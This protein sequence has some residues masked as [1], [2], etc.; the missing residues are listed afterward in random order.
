MLLDEGCDIEAREDSGKTTLMFEAL[1]GEFDC[2][3][4][5]IQAD[6]DIHA[7]DNHNQTAL[8]ARTHSNRANIASRLPELGADPHIENDDGHTALALA[9]AEGEIVMIKTLEEAIFKMQLKI[10]KVN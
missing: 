2:A 4:V 8:M 3:L 9:K 6:A 1:G 5:L 10:P 7:V